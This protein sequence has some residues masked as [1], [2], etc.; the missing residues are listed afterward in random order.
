MVRDDFT[1]EKLDMN[2]KNKSVINDKQLKCD[3]VRLRGV[4]F[5]FAKFNMRREI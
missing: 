4:L 3:K 5:A 2:K 1:T